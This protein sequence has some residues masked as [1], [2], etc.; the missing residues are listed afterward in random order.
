ML[1]CQREA[2]HRWTT[3]W[4]RDETKLSALA[5]QVLQSGLAVSCQQLFC[6]PAVAGD[7]FQPGMVAHEADDVVG[8]FATAHDT[9]VEAAWPLAAGQY[10][11]ERVVMLC[12]HRAAL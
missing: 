12:Q 7:A 3:G 11:P 1:L 6:H 5:L 8:L 10:I 9:T 2:G 4:Q